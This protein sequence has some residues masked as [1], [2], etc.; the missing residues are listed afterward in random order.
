MHLIRCCKTLRVALV[1]L[2]AHLF[3]MCARRCTGAHAR[4]LL[5]ASY[6]QSLY[7][8]KEGQQGQQGLH[9]YEESVALVL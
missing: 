1:A 4:Y 6:C 3:P 7:F 8:S 5:S 2:V 9:T